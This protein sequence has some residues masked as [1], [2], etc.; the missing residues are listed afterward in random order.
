M[1]YGRS[2]PA[3]LFDVEWEQL[4]VFFAKDQDLWQALAMLRAAKNIPQRADILFPFGTCR[5]IPQEVINTKL[6]VALMPYR[7]SRIGSRAAPFNNRI[8]R[9][10][11]IVRWTVGVQTSLQLDEPRAIAA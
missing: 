3:L 6:R 2:L 9:P 1:P 10:L 11:A 4:A 7:L 5:N 8:Q